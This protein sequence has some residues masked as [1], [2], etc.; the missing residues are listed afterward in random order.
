VEACSG[1]LHNKSLKILIYTYMEEVTEFKKEII[2]EGTGEVA[3]AG[4]TVEV[5]YTGTL[6]DG[7]TFDSSRDRGTPFS[8]PLGAGMVIKGWDQGVAGMR[9]GE[10]AKLTIPPSL[11]YGER[12]Y[13]PVIP[14]NATLV[15]EVELLSIR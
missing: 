15:F 3:K 1:T 14:A 6:R 2:T 13:P 9:V 11:G 5:H 8:F 10:K 7:S 12:G 4:D